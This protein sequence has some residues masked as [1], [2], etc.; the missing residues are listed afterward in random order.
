MLLSELNHNAIQAA[1]ENVYSKAKAVPGLILT[2]GDMKCHLFLELSSLPQFSSSIQTQEGDILATALHTEVSWFDKDEK[3]TIKPD[4]TI[5]S[6]EH[7]SIFYKRHTRK[8]P[9]RKQFSFDGYAF[10]FELK[11]IR[12]PYDFTPSKL[13]EIKG[14][15]QKIK[16]LFDRLNSNG[17]GSDTFCY[18]T[19]FS[20]YDC[21]N[22][23]WHNFFRE[24]REHEHWRCIYRTLGVQV[25]EYVA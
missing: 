11:F 17:A 12:G 2:E 13:N 8:L 20:R 3:L 4:I 18:F 19:V 1:I 14:D 5:L 9:P 25:P 22:Q 7:L 24:N 15:F 16:T 6:P 23:D 10:I 21:P